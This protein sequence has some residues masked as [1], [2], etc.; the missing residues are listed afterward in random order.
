MDAVADMPSVNSSHYVKLELALSRLNEHPLFEGIMDQDP[1]PI[2]NVDNVEDSSDQGVQQPYDADD[3]TNAM[4][5]TGTYRCA[6]NLAWIA[7]GWR[8]DPGVPVIASKLEQLSDF[9]F[10][11]PTVR[12]PVQMVIAVPNADFDPLEHRGGLKCVT[13]CEYAHALILKIAS[14]IESGKSEEVLKRWKQVLLTVPMVFEVLQS[15]QD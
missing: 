15:E 7:M 12:F 14:E 5:R 11:E 8:P 4:V 10:H 1:L 2:L 9:H 13:Q 3:Y 6:G